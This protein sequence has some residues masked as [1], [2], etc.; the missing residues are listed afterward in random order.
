MNTTTLRLASGDGVIVRRHDA[1]CFMPQREETSLEVLAKFEAAASSFAAMDLLRQ[2]VVDADFSFS[3]FVAVIWTDVVELMVFGDLQVQTSSPTAPMISGAGS[4]T[5]NEHTGRGLSEIVVSAHKDHLCPVTDLHSGIALA[6]GF[7]LH[8]NLAEPSFEQ[9]RQ[10]APTLES[11]NLIETFGAPPLVPPRKVAQP[12]TQRPVAEPSQSSVDSS[13]PPSRNLE[14]PLIDRAADT[15]SIFTTAAS[16]SPAD[17]GNEPE[18]LPNDHQPAGEGR[19]QVEAAFCGKG[20]PNRPGSALCSCGADVDQAEAAWR[21]I[22][23]P[24]LAI[25]TSLQDGSSYP[26]GGDLAL[27]KE[28]PSNETRTGLSFA[29]SLVS[30][31]HADVIVE[32]WNLHLVDRGSTNGTFV[33]LPGTDEPHRLMPDEKEVLDI[34]STIQIGEVFLRVDPPKRS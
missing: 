20:H 4:R 10:A 3:P 15:S 8:A 21:V 24:V 2:A 26:V 6:G 1:I 5:W 12:V 30:R 11:P 29:G 28:P 31:H 7:E 9:Q 13:P 25:L 22:E 16:G 32:S 34:G 14:H 23:Q 19:L 33:I 18:R 17:A 27:G